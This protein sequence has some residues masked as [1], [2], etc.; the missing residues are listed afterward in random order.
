MKEKPIIFSTPMVKAILDGTKTM[1]RRVIKPQPPESVEHFV[2]YVTVSD[3]GIY[4]GMNNKIG[5]PICKIKQKHNV[6]DILWVRETYTKVDDHYVYLADYPLEIYPCKMKP[7]IFMPKEAARIFLKVKSVSIER[8]QDITE[9]DAKVEGVTPCFWFQPYGKSDE[10]SIHFTKPG[11]EQWQQDI[12]YKA[13]F[14]NLWE[15]LN[16]KRGYS[17]ET[18]PWV[19]VYEFERTSKQDAIEEAEE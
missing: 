18:N 2:Y 7:S 19:W 4:E 15:S 6:G 5:Y 9:K 17:W 16:A 11:N 12:T 14:F 3:D 10:E 13:A 8:L 1:T